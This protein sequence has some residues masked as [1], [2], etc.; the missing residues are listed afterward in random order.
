M[1]YQNKTKPTYLFPVR[2]YW[3][4]FRVFSEVKFYLPQ[5]I[6][7]M[8]HHQVSAGSVG[9]QERVSKNL[10]NDKALEL[11]LLELCVP[12]HWISK[13]SHNL[14]EK[15][16]LYSSIL[17]LTS[18]KVTDAID[19]LCQFVA[20]F[21][22]HFLPNTTPKLFHHMPIHFTRRVLVHIQE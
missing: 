21:F 13:S 11:L 4:V 1:Y 12:I 17:E 15:D 16:D 20:V 9:K 8:W 18:G 6:Q 14:H 5:L 2:A 22:C 3:C 10:F 19:L 7:S